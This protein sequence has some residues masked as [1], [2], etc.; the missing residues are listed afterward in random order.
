M[1]DSF[2]LLGAIPPNAEVGSYN[3]VRVILSYAVA[4]FA[5]YTA[6]LLAHEL[7]TAKTAIERRTL[8]WGGAFAMG[9]G[10]WSMHFIGMLS[11]ETTMAVEY[12]PWLTL[13]SLLIAVGV[14]YGALLVVARQH[15]S[16][17]Q[18]LAGGI[19]L[20]VAICGMHYTGMAAMKMDAD[21]RYLPG[22]FL[23]S[24]GIAIAASCAALWT[25]F[26]LARRDSPD[27]APFKLGAALVMGGAICG[28]HYTGMAAAIFIPFAD[29]RRDPNQS[30]EALTAVTIGITALI[31][32]IA[33]AIAAYRGARAEFELRDSESKLRAVI[34]NALDGL[35][36]INERGAIESFNPAAERLFGYRAE[37]VAGQNIK[38]LM[39]EPYHSGHDHYLA[40]YLATNEAHVIGTAGRE[41]SARRKDGSTFPIDLSV[42]A[43]FLRQGRHFAGIV[44]DITARRETETFLQESMERAQSVV[45]GA[46]DAITTIDDQ[47]RVMEWN[48]QAERIFGWSRAEALG[49]VMAEI[50]IPAAQRSAHYAGMQRYL[51]DGTT[52]IVGKRIEVQAAR[53]SGTT[54]PMEMAVT[55]RKRQGRHTFTAFMR[56]VSAQKSAEAERD[57]NVL[58]LQV[59]NRELDEFAHIVSHDLKEPLRGMRNHAAFLLE[60]FGD[61]LEGDGTRRLTRLIMLSERM[62]HLIDDLLFFSR[63]GR[64]E[65]AI[66]STDLNVIVGEIAQ[67]LETRI[68]E[69]RAEISV[70]RPLPVIWCDRP[71]VTEAFRN[72]ITNAIKYNDKERPLIEI[73]F[74]PSVVTSEGSEKEVFYVKDNGIGIAAEFHEKIFRMFGR[75]NDS[76]AGEQDGTGAGLTFVKKI[77][78]RHG[79][80]IWLHS[81]RGEGTT[82][83]F[84]LPGCLDGK[85]KQA[86]Q[87]AGEADRAA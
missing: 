5:S 67:M 4:T 57:A 66:Q 84:T 50:I 82:F 34:D 44:R 27:R 7:V 73:G 77:I 32:L 18:I 28:M 80:R 68:E 87:R 21:L 41:V 16:G 70:P 86:D 1:L 23:L 76:A 52:N 17:S 43:F 85:G 31:L 11:Y 20:G 55:A 64:D 71:R 37:E 42:S 38:L 40:S 54:F 53:R 2:F 72:L 26:T 14:A 59:S 61:R 47:G 12:D 8:H 3:F 65:L 36:T 33:H 15:L 30:F 79:G 22:L 75:L 35:I 9:A 58:A 49:Q 74:L 69:A 51:S 60:D 45:E 56:D 83:Y 81:E 19:V 78:E 6:L 63:L 48:A 24:I 46:L 62:Q 29:C 10:I 39:P 25:A 13:L